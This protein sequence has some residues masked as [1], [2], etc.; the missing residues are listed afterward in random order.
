MKKLKEIG[1]YISIVF[2]AIIGYV[3]GWFSFIDDKRD[4]R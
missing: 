3:I 2:V 1:L 4:K